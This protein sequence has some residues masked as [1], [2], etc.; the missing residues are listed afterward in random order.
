MAIALF[1]AVQ[2]FA[3]TPTADE[4]NDVAKELYCPLC[5]GITVDVC[6]TQQC[7][8][9]RN[10]IREKLAAGET[11]EEIK[12]YF[13]EQYGQRVVAE[14]AKRGLG[15]A[16]WI[17]PFV[18]LLL[19]LGWGGYMLRNWAS[20]RQGQ[21]ITGAPPGGALPEKYLQQLEEELEES[22]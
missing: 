8:Q 3:Q 18:A 4:V 7:V 11:K 15:L 17:L 20:E 1:A 22:E 12:Q 9:M 14:P 13:I 2:V 16:V 19:G 5:A 6:E 21:S 10:L